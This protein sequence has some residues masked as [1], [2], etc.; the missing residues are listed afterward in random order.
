MK[1]TTIESAIER[2]GS[3][4][5][6][7]W[8]EQDCWLKSLLVPDD[9]F[10]NWKVLDTAKSVHSLYCNID[11]HP[12]L[13][14]ALKGIKAAGGASALHSFNGCFN[15]RNVRGSSNLSCHAYGLAID[16]DAQEMPMGTLLRLPDSIV[17]PFKAQG[18][19]YGGDFMHRKDP[20]HFSYAWE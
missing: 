11:M 16:I 17:E 4:I 14:N 6:G 5:N 20:M 3:I 7:V 18:F 13:F 9:W 8:A 10:P 2:Y 12:A 19:D 15:I 1:C